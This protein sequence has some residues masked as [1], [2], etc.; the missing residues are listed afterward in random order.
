MSRE[1]ENR[2]YQEVVGL[3]LLGAGTLLFLALISYDPHD[4]PGWLGISTSTNNVHQTIFGATGAI[5]ACVANLLFGAASFS[6]RWSYSALE[7][8]NSFRPAG[9]CFAG[10]LGRLCL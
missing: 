3:I 10:S 6:W 9:A 2:L 7:R 5:V 4:V 8:L 1:S